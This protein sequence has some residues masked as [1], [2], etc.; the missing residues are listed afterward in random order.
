MENPL[1]SQD[2]GTTPTYTY[3][4]YSLLGLAP[5]ASVL[6]I[7]QAYRAMSKRYH[8]D[9]TELPIDFAKQKFHQLNEA[10]ATLMNAQQRLI[11]D[12]KIGYSRFQRVQPLVNLQRAPASSTR[13]DR[14]SPAYLDPRDRPLSA[15]EVFALFL[16]GLTFVGCLFLAIAIGMSR[17]DIRVG[18]TSLGWVSSWS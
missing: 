15:G 6:Q 8:P 9:T 2:S 17:G 7:R 11:Y 5:S 3:T 12:Y 10:Y 18:F 4:Y 1:A 13:G 14:P 16:L